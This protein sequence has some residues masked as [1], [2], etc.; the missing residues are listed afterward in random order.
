MHGRQLSSHRSAQ[1]AARAA[2]NRSRP[3]ASE[4]TLWAALSGRKLGV[5]FRRQYVV[6]GYIVDFAAPAVMVAVEVDGGYHEGRG[7]ADA[8]RDREL[9]R[10]GFVVV[11]LEAELVSR[12]L[13]AALMLVGEAI[14]VGR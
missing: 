13:P 5:T 14:A 9:R 7:R 10:F 1:L 12:D 11:R 6:G 8:R 2:E 4:R 3:T